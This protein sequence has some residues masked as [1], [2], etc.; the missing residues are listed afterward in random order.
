MK[1]YILLSTLA[2][3]LFALIGCC[4][5]KVL[6]IG[7][8]FAYS[9]A[10][11]SLCSLLLFL[12]LV[13]HG[14]VMNRK[15]TEFEKNIGSPVFYKTNG[16]F[17]LPVGSVRNGNIYFCEAGIVCV[18]LDGKPHTVDEILVQDIEKYRFDDTHLHIFAKDGRVFLITLPDV[19]TVLTV[20]REKDW[21]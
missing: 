20:L 6:E 7:Q 9:V 19:Q 8:P 4:I 10:G 15:Y 13:I 16:N 11:G 3:F 2:G 18:S 21:I 5:L 1:T 12:F 14:N 17:T